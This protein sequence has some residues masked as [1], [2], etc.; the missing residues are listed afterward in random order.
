M[1]IKYANGNVAEAMLLSRTDTTIRVAM[2][3][4][5][6]VGE[7]SYI[8]GTWVSDDCEPVLIEFAWQRHDRQETVREADCC[9]S[10]ELAA[11]LIHLLFT[12]S[13]ERGIAGD[14]SHE[15]CSGDH[16][17]SLGD[18]ASRAAAS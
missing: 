8:N 13:G 12:D 14:A 1:T 2:A 16:H 9:C 15:Y 6:D 3:G 5:D 7:F 11:R 10:R 18:C 17:P 4:A